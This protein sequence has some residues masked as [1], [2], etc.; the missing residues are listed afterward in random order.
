VSA[1]LRAAGIRR[2]TQTWG[3]KV[4]SAGPKWLLWL[5]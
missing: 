2:R 1:T 5:A 3:Q 4:D